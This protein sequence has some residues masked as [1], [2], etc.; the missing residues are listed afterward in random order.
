MARKC[1]KNVF[2]GRGARKK[3]TDAYL[4]K[5]IEN[6]FTDGQ[7]MH[8]TFFWD[9][10]RLKKETEAQFRVGQKILE[11]KIKNYLL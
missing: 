5:F 10:G 11:Q 1:S 8:E 6:I 3:E 4:Q 9:R 7:K 2:W